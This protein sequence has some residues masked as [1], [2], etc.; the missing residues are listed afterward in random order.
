MSVQQILPIATS[1]SHLRATLL[2]LNRGEWPF[3]PMPWR[4]LAL[5]FPRQKD[6]KPINYATLRRYAHGDKII[7][8]EHRKLLGLCHVARRYEH[9]TIR[10]DDAESAI[11]SL[12]KLVDPDVLA[13]IKKGI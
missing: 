1:E 6:G 10:K 12:K 11:R 3:L 2:M 4:R 9:V 8:K 7:N 13:E 5:T